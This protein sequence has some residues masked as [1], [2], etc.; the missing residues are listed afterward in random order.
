MVGLLAWGCGGYRLRQA[1]GHKL[2]GAGGRRP[3]DAKQQGHTVTG[4]WALAW[5]PNFLL[6]DSFF[7]KVSHK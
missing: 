2:P 1:R 6:F 7:F 4:T 3:S 5:G